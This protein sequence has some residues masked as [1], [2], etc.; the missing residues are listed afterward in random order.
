MLRNIDLAFNFLWCGFFL[1]G[2]LDIQIQGFII[3]GGVIKVVPLTERTRANFRVADE[4]EDGVVVT[5]VDASSK[6]AEAGLK[7]GDVIVEVAR[8]DVGSV[9]DAVAARKKSKSG[10]LLLR[11]VSVDGGTRYLAVKTS[12]D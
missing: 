10:A 6:A 3:V 11:V 8:K 1:R 4:V 12:Q 5:E 9:D 2:E 7:V